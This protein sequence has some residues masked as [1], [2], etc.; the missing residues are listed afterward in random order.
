[1]VT[2]LGPNPGQDNNNQQQPYAVAL[3]TGGYNLTADFG[4]IQARSSIGDT[5]FYDDNRSGTQD[6]DERGI[7]D[8]LVQLYSQDQSGAC[9][10]LLDSKV[11]D[12]NGRYLFTN[13]APGNYCV[14]V[15]ENPADNPGL[16]AFERTAGTNPHKVS[17]PPNGQYL[18]ADFG[19]AGRGPIRGIVFYDWN[20]NGVK[21]L[22][23]D[24]I[25][26]VTVCLY[27]DLDQD[28]VR[29]SNTPIACTTTDSNGSFAFNDQLPGSYLIEQTQPGGLSSTTPNVIPVFLQLT[30]GQGFSDGNDFGEILRV[31]LGDLAWVDANG[32]GAQDAG[33][34]GLSGVPIRITGT[35]IIGRPVDLTVYT[36]SGGLYL[37][38]TLIPGT[39]TATA[40]TTFNA[41]TLNLANNSLTTTLTVS[42]TEDLTLDFPYSYPTV[43][44]VQQFTAGSAGGQVTLNWAV[45][46]NAVEGFRVWRAETDA[47]GDAVPLTETPVAV[48]ADGRAQ[49]TDGTV[50]VGRTY[51]YWLEYLGDGSRVGPVSVTVVAGTP[52]PN[53]VFLPFV[54]R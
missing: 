5:V 1:M 27:E 24:I 38:D 49:Y 44:Q 46:G 26:G 40:P 6:G 25:P 50:V 8:I 33:E 52:T 54:V 15:P 17:L 29:D 43:V 35:D 12:S 51:W 42:I 53:R 48:D 45:L 20:E 28:G 9:S 36:G 18:D 32:N 10:Q 41:Y 21:D 2:A 4:Y 31:R 47:E 34:P 7:P 3:P 22:N 16:S 14:I 30:Q 23:E 19:Y 11:T 37:V 13:L 39:Y